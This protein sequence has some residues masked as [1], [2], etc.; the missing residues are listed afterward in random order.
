V[1][2]ASADINATGNSIALDIAI[3]IGI[4]FTRTLLSGADEAIE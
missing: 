2:K 3:S 4:T 1:L